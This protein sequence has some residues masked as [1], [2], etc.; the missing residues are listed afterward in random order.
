M[1][2][3]Q[4]QRH[5]PVPVQSPRPLTDM[6]S[7]QRRRRLFISHD[8]TDCVH[9]LALTVGEIWS[10]WKTRGSPWGLS[11]T[12]DTGNLLVTLRY[13]RRV[14]EY[15]PEGLL[16]RSIDLHRSGAFSPWHA[17]QTS[18]LS[19]MLLVGHGDRADDAVRVGFVRI[20]DSD[21]TVEQRW[22][23]GRPG[24]SKEL[25]S[26]PQQIAIGLDGTLAVADV[27]N[28]RVV[29]LDNE[30]RHVGVVGVSASHRAEGRQVSRICYIGHRL[31]IA[32]S[33]LVKGKFTTGR[34]TVYELCFEH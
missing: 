30:L 25:L 12:Q 7:C 29:L 4:I 18:S 28:D 31:C 8:A 24:D 14:D 9:V 11:V 3:L 21:D 10:K 23:G 2:N 26:R 27:F 6:A 13:E 17:V 16:L 19:K 22:Y 1:H 5:L 15:S 20:L 34:L 33:Q 32:E